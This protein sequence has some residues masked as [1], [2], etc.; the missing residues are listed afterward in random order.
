MKL[1]HTLLITL[2][3]LSLAMRL[4]AQNNSAASAPS[5]QP[6]TRPAT[7]APND[8]IT[9]MLKPTGGASAKPLKPIENPP[10][11]DQTTG[12]MIAPPPA[13]APQST[14]IREGDWI[15]DR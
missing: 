15:R 7:L 4:A 6:T 3:T 10:I 14:L 11:F 5:T 13:V 9:Q 2:A 12:K 1:R 8:V